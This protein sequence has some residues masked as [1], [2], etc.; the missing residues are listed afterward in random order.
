MSQRDGTIIGV[1]LAAGS[2]R[3]MGRPKQLLDVGGRPLVRIAAEHALAAPLDGLLVVVGAAGDAVAAALAGLPVEIVVNAEYAAGQ[4]SS[5]RA[6][7]AALPPPAGAALILLGDQP[8]VTPAVIAPLVAAWRAGRGPI[9]APVYRG[10]RGTPVLFDRA[11]FAE[12]GAV[13]GDQGA[14]AVIARDP[15]RVAVVPF[16]D[17]RPLVDIDTP[18]EYARLQSEMRNDQ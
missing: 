14:R 2:S 10:Q 4:S 16:D 7:V 3:R 15:S 17:D 12:L 8:F 9:V 1:M 5:L 6:G 13:E 18:E 11:L